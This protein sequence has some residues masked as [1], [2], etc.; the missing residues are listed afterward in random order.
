M[1]SSRPNGEGP[2]I[3]RRRAHATWS[4]NDRICERKWVERRRTDVEP[5]ARPC[6]DPVAHQ[7]KETCVSTTESCP[8][9]SIGQRFDPL[10]P[11]QLEDPY[12]FYAE[13]RR[14]E[15]VSTAGC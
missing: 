1:N 15:P 11:E 10:S 4:G 9:S 3:S 2:P 6:P 14:E 13:A 5:A 12:S 7:R 8:M